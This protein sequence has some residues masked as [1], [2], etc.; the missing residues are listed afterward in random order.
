MNNQEEYYKNSIF[1]KRHIISI[2]HCGI[3]FFD[4]NEVISK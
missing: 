4:A 1:V 2:L 3:N